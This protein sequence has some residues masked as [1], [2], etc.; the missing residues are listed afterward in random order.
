MKLEQKI[1]IIA[2]QLDVEGTTQ[3]EIRAKVAETL[4]K[5]GYSSLDDYLRKNL[6]HIL[7]K[8]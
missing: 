4:G 8:K 3:Q 5:Q 7:N 2:Q 1:L 6:P